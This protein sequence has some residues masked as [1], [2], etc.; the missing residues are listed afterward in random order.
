M[1]KIQFGR[2]VFVDSEGEY[3]IEKA[4]R[5]L[6]KKVQSSNILNE[7]RERET[8]EKPTT[9]RKRLKNVARRRW[10]KKIEEE[11]LTKSNY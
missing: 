9:R 2:T 11:K 6:K 4:L 7:L 3:A 1:S 10:L 5:K 8:Y